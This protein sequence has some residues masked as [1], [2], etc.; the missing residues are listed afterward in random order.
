[1]NTADVALWR[2]IERAG[3]TG[4][5]TLKPSDGA[6]TVLC[7]REALKDDTHEIL[8]VGCKN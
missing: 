1:T 7:F 6:V 2:R 5:P 3:D 4:V 8:A